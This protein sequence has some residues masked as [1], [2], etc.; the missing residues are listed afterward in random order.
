M[1]PRAFPPLIPTMLAAAAAIA[2]PDR[3]RRAAVMRDNCPD[4]AICVY[5]RA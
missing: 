1:I 4:S 3:Q 5:N 2:G